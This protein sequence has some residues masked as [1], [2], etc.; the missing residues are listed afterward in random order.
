MAVI[1]VAGFHHETN[2]F[3]PSK[4]TYADFESGGGWPPLTRGARAAEVVDGMNVALGGFAAA[5]RAAGHRLIPLIWANATP[6]AHVTRDAYERISAAL[7]EELGRAEK[8]DAVYLDLHGAMVT[9]HLDDGEGE[10]LTRVRALVGPRTPVVVTLDYHANVTR[11]MV[12]AA[13]T[14]I[15]YRT[16]PHI[17]MAETGRRAAAWLDRILKRGDAPLKAFRQ[18]GF[19][20]PLTAQCTLIE[21]SIKLFDRLAAL[22]TEHDAM[23]TFAGG[24]PAA[25]IVDCGPSVTGFGFDARAADAAERLAQAI[26]DA[27]GEFQ[28]EFLPPD[29]GVARAIA[30]AQPG[31]PPVILADTQDNPGAGANGDTVGILEA[32]LRQRAQGAVVGLLIDPASARRA[33]ET[34]VGV[35]REFALG[36][37]S[38]LPGHAPCVGRFAVERLGDGEFIGSGPFYRGSKMRLGPM[39]LLRRD[40]VSVVVA[41]KKVQAADQAMFRCL[42]VE[43]QRQSILSLKSSVHFRADF[44]PIASE[45]LVIAA[46]GPMAADPAALA[47]SKLRRGVRL[48]PNGPEF[49]GRT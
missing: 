15:G 19:L 9:E 6:S 36:A 43:P 28:A 17:D 8:P 21:P 7:L 31:G 42:G 10:L 12:D 38:G 14:L 33:H 32:L 44:G 39:A 27:E 26:A 2:T 24:F 37:I 1:A 5:A 45:V 49:R 22:E 34:G 35:A 4:A 40:G 16:Y 41:S 3:A 23:L 18:L 30:R 13:D 25:D 47:W 46:P 11:A 20:I 29:E 48:G